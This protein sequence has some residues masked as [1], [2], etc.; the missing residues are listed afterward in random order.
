MTQ[1]IVPCPI[2]ASEK[3]KFLFEGWDVQFGYP[4]PVMVY[5]CTGWG[6]W[7]V[8]VYGTCGLPDCPAAW[9]DGRTMDIPPDVVDVCDDTVNA[10]DLHI[11]TF[12]AA[13]F[14]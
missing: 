11:G 14:S 5:Q 3:T 1:A 7:N 10:V 8:A 9:G 2:C 13:F 12:L 4:D 6:V